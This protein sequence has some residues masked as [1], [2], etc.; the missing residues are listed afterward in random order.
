MISCNVKEEIDQLQELFSQ[1]RFVELLRS[2]KE[3]TGKPFPFI[4]DILQTLKSST[5]TENEI[6]GIINS[7]IFIR[8]L[9]E[10]V[11]EEYLSWHEDTV[12][13]LHRYDIEDEFDIEG[14]YYFSGIDVFFFYSKWLTVFPDMGFM[15]GRPEWDHW[16]LYEAKK[17]GMQIKEIKNKM[18]FHIKH[19]QRW[20]PT[21][22]NGMV[23]SKVGKNDEGCIDEEY[24]YQTN[25]LMS[26]LSY[27]I[28][29]TENN[30][31]SDKSVIKQGIFYD[32]V[33]RKSVLSWEK[34]VYH[35]DDISES[36]GIVYFRDNRAYRICALHSELKIGQDEKFLPGNILPAGVAKGSILKYIDFKDFSFVP[37][38]GKVYIYPAGRA[39]RLLADCL[40]TYHIPI[41]GMID[42]D[43]SLC[44]KKYRGSEIF[45]I[46]VLDD[47][48]AY[49]HVLVATN[50]YVRE[51]YETLKE[52]VPE[53]K[54]IVL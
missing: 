18:A 21:D 45:D 35:R 34:A 6:C 25:M 8:N 40:C 10:E 51:I 44:G 19:K 26:D 11:I 1:V 42:R 49:D 5:Y 16:F 39:A 47:V 52:K 30:M 41:L 54:L 53:D 43:V 36:M 46:S 24:Y 3:Q 12:L 38:L 37:N 9:S 4:Y 14:E 13:T 28:L 22:S 15:L 23:I 17:A 50:L 31:K 27:R 2:G 20:T 32:D 33:D 29:L 7:D 48:E